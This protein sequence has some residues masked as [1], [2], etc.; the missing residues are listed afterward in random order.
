MDLGKMIIDTNHLVTKKLPCLSNAGV[1]SVIKYYARGT[2]QP[3]KLLTRDEAQSVLNSGMTLAVIYEGA[4][5][6]SAY[7]SYDSGS[8]DG[9]YARKYAG[10][11]IGQPGGSAIYFAVDY[12][13]DE[14]DITN[15]IIPYFKGVRDSLNLTNRYPLYRIG[16]YGNGTT[17]QKLLDENLVEFTWIS[18]S[19]G[20]SGS[21]Q[22]KKSNHWTLFQN[23]PS[24]LCALD[25]DANDLNPKVTDFGEFNSLLPDDAGVSA[26]STTSVVNARAGARLRS[27]PGVEFDVQRILRPHSKVSIISRRGDWS[28]VD[29]KGDG[30]TDGFI[31]SAFLANIEN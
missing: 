6:H 30:L 18:Q 4:G 8:A 14:P 22:F 20:F 28:L 7:F 25:L 1:K 21:K 19:I 9:M 29:L 23:M 26:L 16:A 11:T 10:G 17:L 5:D 2:N 15:R 31:H 3:E 24:V 12:D 13:S 27:G